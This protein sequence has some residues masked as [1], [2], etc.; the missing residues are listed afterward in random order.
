MAPQQSSP[1]ALRVVSSS[2]L[3]SPTT[4]LNACR[5]KGV[6]APT[7][8]PYDLPQTQCSELVGSV[9]KADGLVGCSVDVINSKQVR[10]LV[11]VQSFC[12]DVACLALMKVDIVSSTSVDS[13]DSSKY[14]GTRFL[15][16]SLCSG[17]CDVTSK[18][19]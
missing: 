9:N 7:P 16:Y 14:D 10:K 18:Q 8:S 15:W 4:E 5:M 3:R 19:L 13:R 17:L 1:P 6:F 12:F 11:K 2:G